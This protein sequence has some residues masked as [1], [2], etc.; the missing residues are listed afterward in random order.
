MSLPSKEIIQA[1]LR[2]LNTKWMGR[3]GVVKVT[4]QTDGHGLPS[5]H[6]IGVDAQ[7]PAGLPAWMIVPGEGNRPFKIPVFYRQD[8]A[9][10]VNQPIPSDKPEIFNS[11]AQAKLPLDPLSDEDVDRAYWFFATPADLNRS[12]KNYLP[13][14]HAI[15]QPTN[16]DPPKA[17]EINTQFH[18][19]M[20]LPQYDN[21]NFWSKP[22]EPS[23]CL[24]CTWYMRPTLV[25]NFQ[26]PDTYLVVVNGISYDIPTVLPFGT[27]FQVEILRGGN[28]MASFEEIVVDPANP[29]PGLR[30][31]FASHPSP[32]PL[33]VLVDRGQTLGVRITVKGP[34][35]FTK[36]RNDTF[37][38]TICILLHG[39]MASLMDNRDGAP[40]P[41]DVGAMLDGKGDET[42]PQI[43]AAD[44]RELLTWIGAVTGSK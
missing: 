38:G 5:Y 16:M 2:Q 25:Y 35:P 13:A 11:K 28:V 34:F 39:W 32:T 17:D 22:F 1:G 43:D 26:V 7:P 41:S 8:V 15:P 20:R 37:C 29:N 21:E 27:I 10:P 6:F 14:F 33:F 23:A 44:V 31:A 18:I 24:C 30:V 19:D 3:N 42:V 12:V 40:R 4:M 36:T 9:K